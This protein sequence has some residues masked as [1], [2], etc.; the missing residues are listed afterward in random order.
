[1]R[2]MAIIFAPIAALL[3]LNAWGMDGLAPEAGYATGEPV[4][5]WKI[6]GVVVLLA[7]AGMGANF[8]RRWLTGQIPGTLIGYLFT[9]NPR[10]TGLALFTLIGTVATAILAGQFDGVTLK[11]LFLPAFLL[12]YAADTLNKGANPQA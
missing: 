4:E 7:L 8:L 9:D 12:G 10:R 6:Y 1:M 3:A 11:Q 5:A 2:T